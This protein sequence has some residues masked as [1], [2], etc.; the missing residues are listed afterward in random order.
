[1]TSQR[2]R[3]TFIMTLLITLVACSRPNVVVPSESLDTPAPAFDA[4]TLE[5]IF[6]A[7]ERLGVVSFMSTAAD[8]CVS[9]EYVRGEFVSDPSLP[10]CGWIMGRPPEAPRPFDARAAKDLVMIKSLFTKAEFPLVFLAIK[11]DAGGS[12]AGGSTFAS[13]SCRDYIYDQG[14]S[15]AVA[16]KG[17][18]VRRVSEAWSVLSRC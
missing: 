4:T 16:D 2:A 7:L 17:E 14:N 6:P 18:A 1:M 10:G 11:R 13:E 15:L 3:M 12:I 9:F 5:S 8:G